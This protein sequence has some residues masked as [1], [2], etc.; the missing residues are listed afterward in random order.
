MGK[1]TDI[2]GGFVL[3][4]LF[5]YVASKLGLTA[6]DILVYAKHFFS[7]IPLQWP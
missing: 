7:G 6:G 4:V 3:F 1:V 2:V 5:L